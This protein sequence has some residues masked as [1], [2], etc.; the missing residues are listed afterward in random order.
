M[1]N[2]EDLILKSCDEIVIMIYSY[3]TNLKNLIKK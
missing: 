2:K 1:G 3:N